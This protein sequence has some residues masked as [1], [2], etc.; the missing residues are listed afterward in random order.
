MQD[1]TPQERM[2][3]GLRA[4]GLVPTSIKVDKHGF[5]ESFSA[6]S[7]NNP[8]CTITG[9][10]SHSSE[11]LMLTGFESRWYPRTTG[12]HYSAPGIPTWPPAGVTIA[13]VIRD[14]PEIC[15]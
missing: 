8:S 7:V 12:Y 14:H 2:N 5:I 15:Q 11:Q 4:E 6:Y 9:S 10:Q 1:M 13:D 3:N